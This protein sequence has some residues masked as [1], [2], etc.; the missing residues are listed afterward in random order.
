MNRKF[1]ISLLITGL[2]VLADVIIKIYIKN[3]AAIGQII[4]QIKGLILIAKV[5]TLAITPG[6]SGGV[7]LL[8]MLVIIFQLV[9]CLVAIRLFKRA[10]NSMFMLAATLLV[11]GWVGSY[12]DRFFLSTSSTYRQLDY[13]N[14]PFISAA[15]I[16]LS[17]LL[18]LT[19]FI[20]FLYFTI[21]R[22]RE[23]KSFFVK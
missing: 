13:L 22:F 12:I 18:S 23:L 19:G 1:T 8:S 11:A 21:T 5:E 3:N 10:R 6:F 20:L 17:Y 4:W 15:F 9:F 16:N 14:L 7:N 2:I